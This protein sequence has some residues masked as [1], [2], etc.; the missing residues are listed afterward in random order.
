MVGENPLNRKSK[1]LLL[2]GD[3][4]CSSREILEK[5]IRELYSLTNCMNTK[6]ISFGGILFCRVVGINMDYTMSISLLI[7][8][9]LAA[10]ST[11]HRGQLYS[12]I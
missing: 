4:V 10:D 5:F 11:I 9:L 3:I 6:T 1:H 12:N 7:L 2:D 8:K